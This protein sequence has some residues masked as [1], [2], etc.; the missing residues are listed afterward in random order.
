M[1]LAL[2]GCGGGS[3]GYTQVGSAPTGS[4][5]AATVRD[6]LTGVGKVSEERAKS[7]PVA[8]MINN[9]TVAQKAQTGLCAADIVYETYV[10]GGITRLM[11]VYGD[12]SEAGQIGTVRSGRYSYIDLANGHGA[13]YV[14]AGIDGAFALPYANEVTD[15]ID[16]LQGAAQEASFREENG[17]A[18][19]HRLY[20][21]GGKLAKTAASMGR[22]MTLSSVPSPWQK[23]APESDPI[24]PEGLLPEGTKVNSV[25]IPMSTKEYTSKFV[26]NAETGKYERTHDGTPYTDCKT[27]ET[28][29]SR[30]L[31]ILFTTV[32]MLDDE[33][34]K[35][36][37][38][39][40]SGYY[41]S[42]GGATELRWEKGGTND[43]LT[44]Y[45]LDGQRL[46]V[47]PGNSW[48]FIARESVRGAVVFG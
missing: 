28:V 11:A 23:F 44:F 27:G 24:V 48:V 47:N 12:I 9:I 29:A 36:A 20:T 2:C 33:H 8:V 34:V 17:L 45:G 21:S 26:Y 41:I 13:L 43:P 40:G 3:G 35:Q 4:K 30:N 6:P 39:G 37:L 38:E 25:T 42:A 19:E 16:L 32:S 5:S 1:F 46:T 31:F 15:H 14:H 22:R 18:Y 10:E 7:R